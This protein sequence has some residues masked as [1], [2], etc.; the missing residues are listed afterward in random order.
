MT[1]EDN[2]P[3]LIDLHSHLLPGVDDGSATPEL[4][5]Q[6]AVKFWN[7]GVRQLF[8]TP[9]VLLSETAGASRAAVIERFDAAHQALMAAT[10][11]SPLLLLR[12]AEVM[13]DE[14]PGARHDLGAPLTL[15]ESNA[16]LIEFPSSIT[17]PGGHP[18]SPTCGH[19]KLL[20]LGVIV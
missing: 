20:H 14:P 17:S 3:P 19:P 2:T 8:L 6:V 4:S 9:H 15:G 10:G 1:S 7:D 18:K 16:V 12:G 11:Q 5:A 13:I